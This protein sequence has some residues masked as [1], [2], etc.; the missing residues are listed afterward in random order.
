MVVNNRHFSN[1]NRIPGIQTPSTKGTVNPQS[2][3]GFAKILEEKVNKSDEL[4]FS[5]HAEMRLRIRNINLS[6]EQKEK[7]I[8]G[9]KKANEKG[10]KDSLV[11]VDNIAFVI[12]VK[13][14]TVITAVAKDELKENVF[15]NIDGAVFT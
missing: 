13:N 15:T 9:V 14:R 8:A 12:N 7:I 1:V 3:G 5:K 11:M 10:V 6:P 2:K 4:K